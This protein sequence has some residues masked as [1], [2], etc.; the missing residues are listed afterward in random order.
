MSPINSAKEKIE[1][2]LLVEVPPQEHRQTPS[3]THPGR[4]RE[5]RP[6][7]SLLQAGLL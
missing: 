6:R 5:A 1:N 4:C 3:N 2:V 7:L